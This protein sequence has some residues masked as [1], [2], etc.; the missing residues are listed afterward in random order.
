MKLTPGVANMPEILAILVAPPDHLHV[1][2]DISAIVFVCVH[3]TSVV[4]DK[5]IGAGYAAGDWPSLH[6]L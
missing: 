3:P 4:E 6:D 1:M 5:V 2:V